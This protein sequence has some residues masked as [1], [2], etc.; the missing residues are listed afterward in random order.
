VNSAANPGDKS[1]TWPRTW[2]WD[3]PINS[4]AKTITSKKNIWKKNA[5]KINQSRHELI[6]K[7]YDPGHEVKVALLNAGLK[8]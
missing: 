1:N 6:F 3:D 4:K 7:M 5:L 2:N 8:K